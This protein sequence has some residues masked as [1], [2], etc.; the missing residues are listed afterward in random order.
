LIVTPPTYVKRDGIQYR[1]DGV[2]DNTIFLWSQH[3]RGFVLDSSLGTMI[4]Q[5]Y[6]PV[7]LAIHTPRPQ[8]VVEGILGGGNY[9]YRTDF[10]TSMSAQSNLNL[11]K[12]YSTNLSKLAN[13]DEP[14]SVLRVRC[15]PVV[16]AIIS[17]IPAKEL[18]Q[19][20]KSLYGI[21]I[22]KVTVNY[23]SGGY[24]MPWTLEELL[25]KVQEQGRIHLDVGVDMVDSV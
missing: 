19:G 25:R 15:L 4:S 8:K 7:T 20:V 24:Q 12:N 13:V 18:Y 5:N 2:L 3:S 6:H 22:P 10:H 9:R 16:E 11:L 17:R 1:V 21:E 23:L 14:S